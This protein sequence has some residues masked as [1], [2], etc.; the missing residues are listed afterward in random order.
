MACVPAHAIC[1]MPDSLLPLKVS[2][3][4]FSVKRKPLLS[5][6]DLEI[7]SAGISVILGPNGAG[8]SL[9]VRL[10]H[11]LLKPDQGQ[12]IWN[13]RM[14][15]L[16]IRKQQAMVFQKPVLLRR[17]VE[18]NIKFVLKNNAPDGRHECED[19]LQQAGLLSQRHQPARLLSGGEQQRLALARALATSPQVLFLDEPTASIDPG[20]TLRI[21]NLLTVTR[22]SGV[23]LILVTHDIGQAHRLAGDVLFMHHGQILEHTDAESFFKQPQ[24]AEANAFLHGELIV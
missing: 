21:E 6:L 16:S 4:S 14:L 10:L 5:K 19:I 7:K 1:P 13:G 12:I 22:D 8:K 2:G 18:A 11:G 15:D 23:K 17:S 24:S 20:S 3:L 9:L